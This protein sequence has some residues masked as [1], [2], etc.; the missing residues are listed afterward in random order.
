MAIRK[1]P[2]GHFIATYNGKTKTF[3]KRADAE[4]WAIQFNTAP[5]RKKAYS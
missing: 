5:K 4:K 1:S 3:K 2:K